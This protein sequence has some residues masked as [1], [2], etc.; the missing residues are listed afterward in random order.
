M[1]FKDTS[2]EKNIG[3]LSCSTR[4]KRIKCDDDSLNQKDNFFF[5]DD[6]EKSFGSIIKNMEFTSFFPYPKY[7]K[8]QKD[9]IEKIELNSRERNNILLVAPNGTGKTVIALSALLPVALDNKMKIIYMCRTHSQN[10]RV[11]KELVKI[12][13]HVEKKKPQL[14]FS[15]MAIRGRN[16]MCLNKTLLEVNPSPSDSMTLCKNLRNNH[17]CSHFINLLNRKDS[18]L[19]SIELSG[20]LD[21]DFLI[22]YCNKKKLCPY[23]LTKLLMKNMNLVICNYNWLFNSN[24]KNIFLKY[25]ETSLNN[26]I[27]IIDECHNIIDVSTNNNSSKISPYFLKYCYTDLITYKGSELMIKFVKL[28]NTILEKAKEKTKDIEI[29]ID[30]D[31]FLSSL[32]KRFRFNNSNDFLLFIEQIAEFSEIVMFNKYRDNILTKDYLGNLAKF[33]LKWL[34]AY[35]SNSYFFCFYKSQKTKNTNIY[36][37][38]VSLDPRI[39]TLPL[40]K[41]SFASLHLTGTVNPHVYSNLIGLNHGDKTYTEIITPSPFKKENI[42]AF[43]IKDLN[44]KMT[45]RTPSMYKEMLNRIEEVISSTP[46]NIGIFCASYRIGKSLLS[47]GL[48]QI[49]HNNNKK[50]FIERSTNTASENAFLLEDFKSMASKRKSGGVLLGVCGGRNSEG[51]DYPGG[52]MNA[53]IIAGFPYQ[54]PTPRV[55]AKIKYYDKVFNRQGWNFAYLYPAIQKAN[56]ASGRPIR[57]ESDKGAIIFLDERFIQKRNWI[58]NWL[59]NQVKV[60]PNQD[61]IIYRSLTQFWNQ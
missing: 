11:I 47:N 26:C 39:V 38:I 43:I 23:F 22:D 45:N 18:I 31:D 44:T 14:R 59:K 25:L 24:I 51:E 33:W 32:Y 55:D 1:T 37:E 21:A 41:A 30:P 10:S 60:V 50:L 54:T 8:A 17:S 3:D 13:E 2:K 4:Q 56:Q 36:L 15:A 34:D 27:I 20:I 19:N 58:S 61:G 57:R 40:L 29:R 9:I 6:I 42:K 35:K 7:R 48:E 28:L 52:L 49:V 46:A 16:E 5:G 12:S 53:V